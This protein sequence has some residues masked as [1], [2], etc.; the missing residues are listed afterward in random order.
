MILVIPT[1]FQLSVWV[2]IQIQGLTLWI[3]VMKL[4]KVMKITS[5][6]S[7]T[8]Y[9]FKKRITNQKFDPEVD[10]KILASYVQNTSQ[11]GRPGISIKKY[12][13]VIAKVI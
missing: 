1:Y 8:L 12:N 2:A 10:S 6:T 13:K 3:L 7:L 5:I 9:K 11:F 4:D